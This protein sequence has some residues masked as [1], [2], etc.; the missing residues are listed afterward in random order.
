MS[1]LVDDIAVDESAGVAR[2]TVRL[3]EASDTAVAVHWATADGSARSGVDYT[4]RAGVLGFDPGQLSLV[5]TV[6]LLDNA[7]H[8]GTELFKLT[9]FDPVNDDI[10]RAA[11]WA[12]VLDDD[13]PAGR[14]TLRVADTVVDDAE[15]KA[16]FT[17][18]LDR[19]S[20]GTVRVNLATADGSAFA[21]NDFVALAPQTLSFAPGEVVKTVAVDVMPR[22][23]SNTPSAWFDLQLSAPTG[24]NLP[25]T[26]ARAFI[27]GS[28]DV[29]VFPVSDPVISV[30]DAQAGESDATLD[31]VVNLSAKPFQDVSVNWRVDGLT[32]RAGSDFV[33]QSGTLVFRAGELA[34]VLHV[35][36]LED[37]APESDELVRLSLSAPVNAQLGDGAGDVLGTIHDND[38]PS[39]T[40]VIRVDD[41]I[42]DNY[43]H[44]ARFNVWLDRPSTAPVTVRYAT[45]DASASSSR[46]QGDFAAQA[47]QTLV[48]AP[49]ETNKTVYVPIHTVNPFVIHADSEFFDLQ[50]SAPTGATLGDAR[51]HMVIPAHY[52]G[53]G[54]GGGGVGNAVALPSREADTVLDV[55][56]LAQPSNRLQ[57]VSYSTQD[58]S[59]HAGSDYVAQS[60]TVV[61]APGQTLQVLHIPLLDDGI[62]ENTE[63]FTIR[64]AGAGVPAVTAT[65]LDNERIATGPVRAVGSPGGDNVLIGHVGTDEVVGGLGNDLLDGVAGVTLRGLGGNDAYLVEARGDVVVEQP[66]DG[67]DAVWAYL[68]YTLPANVEDL[69]LLGPAQRASGNALDNWMFGN[70]AANAMSGLD[71][72]DT[73]QGGDGADTLN[74][75]N[76]D[77]ELRG[78]AGNDVLN[79][80]A[81][82]DRLRGNEGADTLDGQGGDDLLVGDMDGERLTGG[83][84]ADVFAIPFVSPYWDGVL[85]TVVT[86][87]SSPDDR[88][89]LGMYSSIGDRDLTIDNPL[90]RGAPGGFSTA[91]DLVIFTRDIGGDITAASAAAQIGSATSAYAANDQ[92][93]F[94]VDNGAQ[95]G[96]FLFLSD[97]GDGRVSADE[98]TLIVLA[99]G[100]PSGLSDYSFGLV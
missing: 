52:F 3:S 63:T 87:F 84:G 59:A 90:V 65:I 56:L 17:L 99:D 49:G 39:G 32:A 21:G 25:D 85:P 45:A 36:L 18:V 66:G 35:P 91:S 50:L 83:A 93:L 68:D 16:L 43:E 55:L 12:T 22:A 74:G 1:I 34:Q 23:F 53:S 51:A 30:L 80:G 2:F 81:G 29:R 89:V 77:D 40:P 33:A 67:H 58:G 73:L 46:D 98:L 24:L 57:S 48:F 9:L 76:G 86:D 41:G 15:G 38:R 82:N 97:G 100:G 61:F 13:A 42:V 26:N 96:V 95:T 47:L 5:V 4:A 72:R 6:P 75:G 70:A 78:E 64:L 62:A 44:L 31:F 28:A 19:P 92:R 88:F 8:E 27:V 20:T 60:G 54:S 94:V 79:G 11:A 69:H 10:G 7:T 71:G 37:R 14:P